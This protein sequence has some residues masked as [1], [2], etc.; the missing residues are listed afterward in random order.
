M[1]VKTLYYGVSK[2][3]VLH[4]ANL[5]AGGKVLHPQSPIFQ[6]LHHSKMMINEGG[7]CES[8]TN[9]VQFEY[10]CLCVA[11]FSFNLW[12]LLETQMFGS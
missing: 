4:G 11:Q 8:S 1:N 2:T 12:Q 7:L 10:Y 3:L 5:V 9:L 6:S